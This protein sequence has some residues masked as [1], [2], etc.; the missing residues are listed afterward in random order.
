MQP[1]FTVHAG[2]MIVADALQARFGK[3]ANV[4]IPTKDTGVDL[5]VSDTTNRKTVSLQVKHSRCYAYP[6]LQA[7][8]GQNL[9]SCGWWRFDTQKLKNS[10]ADLWVL[11]II[12]TQQPAVHFIFIE[13]KALL[14]R[15][16]KLRPNASSTQSH[17][18]IERNNCWET[19]GLKQNDKTQL[20][21][22]AFTPKSRNF[23][24]FLGA[25]SKIEERIK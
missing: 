7:R 10:P 19:M 18:W 3:H 22:G 2:E 25:W 11:I 1:L 17:L 9:T 6:H 20:V 15:I 21:S 24:E 8:F 14:A 5:L 16:T 23:S 12:G 13:P 4:W